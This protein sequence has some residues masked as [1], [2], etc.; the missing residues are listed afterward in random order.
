MIDPVYLEIAKLC[1]VCLHSRQQEL[2]TIYDPAAIDI[3]RAG[4]TQY[5][6][7]TYNTQ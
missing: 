6:Y 5:T 4:Y 7:D 2:A 3:A 1:T